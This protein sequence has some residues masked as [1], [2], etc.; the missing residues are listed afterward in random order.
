MQF[1]FYIHFLKVFGVTGFPPRM[2][3]Q[4]TN[5]IRNRNSFEKMEPDPDQ[6]VK[7]DSYNSIFFHFWTAILLSLLVMGLEY[8]RW[9]VPIVLWS[10]AKK[11]IEVTASRFN[12]ESNQI[13]V[14][15]HSNLRKETNK[16]RL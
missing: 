10:K 11:F 9:K 16:I 6:V 13:I 7:L 2:D 1:G 14:I 5:C 4:V 3:S 15:N 8:T 12:Q